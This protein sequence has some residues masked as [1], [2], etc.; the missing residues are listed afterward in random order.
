MKK[1]ICILALMSLTIS[2]TQ[3]IASWKRRRDL[4]RVLRNTT[5]Q[6]VAQIPQLLE[7]L[8]NADT[9]QRAEIVRTLGEIGQ[10]P[11]KVIPALVNALKDEAAIVRR[12][13]AFALGDMG[14][15]A[16]SAIPQ[17]V[18]ALG[19]KEWRPK[20]AAAM[21][22]AEIGAIEEILAATT[23][24]DP[25]I[26]RMATRSLVDLGEDAM[27]YIDIIAKLAK[28]QNPDVVREAMWSLEI[29]VLH[30]RIVT[31]KLAPLVRNANSKNP[32][33]RLKAAKLLSQEG[34]DAIPILL[35]LHKDANSQVSQ[36]AINALRF[37][38]EKQYENIVSLKMDISKKAKLT[39]RQRRV[40]EKKENKKQKLDL[41]QKIPQLLENLKSEDEHSKIQALEVLGH[42]QTQLD[43]VLPAIIAATQ[44][45]NTKVRQQAALALGNLGER[46]ISAKANL[47][48]MFLDKEWLPKR[49]AALA[50]A[51]MNAR[52]DIFQAILSEDSRIREMAARSIADMENIHDIERV[53]SLLK[54]EKAANVQRELHR[55]LDILQ[56]LKK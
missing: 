38:Q 44:D 47:L 23:S 51:E 7:Q 8:K 43:I 19:D 12:Y 36:A 6:M 11:Q 13:A 1:C 4:Q 22:L 17:L 54:T 40:Y 39:W 21:A 50:L 14:P 48:Q 34:T 5:P 10:Q 30:N 33:V 53:Q 20:R 56:S 26:R 46:A 25:Q 16:T 24:S 9:R 35:K 18:E 3:E 27:P 42:T 31:T 45:T 49:A 2:H 52:D 55:T 37:I 29:L 32:K 41:S 15:Q 28:D